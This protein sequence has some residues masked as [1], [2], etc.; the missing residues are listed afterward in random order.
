M[1]STLHPHPQLGYMYIECTLST[2]A[3]CHG[4]IITSKN[5]TPPSTIKDQSHGADINTPSPITSSSE[6]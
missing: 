1:L 6:C 3:I 4:L 5:L 2:L